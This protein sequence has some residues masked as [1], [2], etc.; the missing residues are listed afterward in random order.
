MSSRELDCRI[1]AISIAARKEVSP[2]WRNFRWRRGFDLSDRP[3]LGA[4]ARNAG[5]G[6]SLGSAGRSQKL[7]FSGN[8]QD[9]HPIRTMAVKDLNRNK[10]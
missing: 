1:A 3:Q 4:S 9:E 5:F 2:P 8:A 6:S 7:P 10:P